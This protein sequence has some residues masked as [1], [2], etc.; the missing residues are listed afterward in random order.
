MSFRPIFQLGILNGKRSGREDK[1]GGLP[2]GL[3]PD[4]WPRCAVC[5]LPQVYLAQFRNSHKIDLGREQRSL[6]LFQ[7]PDGALC[8]SWDHRTGAN[9]AILIEASD[10]TETTTHAPEGTQVEPEGII[11]GWNEVTPPLH[12]IYAGGNPTFLANH[13][14]Y[15]ANRF[16]G[17][18]PHGRFL[19]QLIDAITFAGAPPTIGETGAQHLHYW[20]G[21]Y[22]QDN[23]RI[24]DPPEPRR[25]YGRWSTGQTDVPGR[26]SQV[27]IREDGEWLV[28]WANFGNGTAYVFMNDE[29][30]CAYM[31]HEN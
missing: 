13:P 3:P 11:I 1:L 24:E 6:F 21:K 5:G 15:V 23:V 17:R 31:F 8:E 10:M 16:G 30:G 18:E 19:L 20:G 12:S 14:V 28:P 26:P 2:F 25:H 4:R 27:I 7:C 22:G 9:A 29:V